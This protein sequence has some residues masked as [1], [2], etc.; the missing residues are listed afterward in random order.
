MLAAAMLAVVLTPQHRIVGDLALRDQRLSDFLNDRRE[1]VIRLVN[2]SVSRASEP[3]AAVERHATAVIHKRGALVV[4]GIADP[5]PTSSQRLYARVAKQTH[6][7]LLAVD[8]LEVRGRLHTS[9]GLDAAEIQR[10]TSPRD[11]FLPITDAVVSV[12]GMHEHDIRQDTLMVNIEH[13]R[14]VARVDAGA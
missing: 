11:S 1:S 13:I 9:G 7:V 12:D 4:F 2:A 10:L 5:S 14:F 3:D 6:E 8:S